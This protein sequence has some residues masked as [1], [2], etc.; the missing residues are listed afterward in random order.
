MW[1]EIQIR[2]LLVKDLARISLL[3]RTYK[4]Q[5]CWCQKSGPH[6]CGCTAN[7]S[8][9]ACVCAVYGAWHFCHS[10]FYSRQR[11]NVCIVNHSLAYSLIG[12]WVPRWC[13]LAKLE[14]TDNPAPV[15]RYKSIIRIRHTRCIRLIGPLWT[16][17]SWSLTKNRNS[18]LNKIE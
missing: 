7:G 17:W 6:L 1:N 15:L 4:S 11:V 9:W 10:R 13:V 12:G 16:L 3:F 14:H 18:T 2:N 5:Y 8:E